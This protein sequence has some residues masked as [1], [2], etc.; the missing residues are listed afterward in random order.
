MTILLIGSQ[1]LQ[2]TELV[3]IVPTAMLKA[4]DRQPG[5][6]SPEQTRTNSVD[7]LGSAFVAGLTGFFAKLADSWLAVTGSGRL[8]L[9]P[10]RR[11]GG[12]GSLAAATRWGKGLLLI[13]LIV[14]VFTIVGAQ[15]RVLSVPAQ[16]EKYLSFPG[17]ADHFL[18]PGTIYYDSK[19]G[20]V[21]VT[22]PGHNRIA[23]FDKSG[24]FKFEFSGSEHY[25]TPMSLAVDNQGRI[26]VLGT[27]PAGRKV[28]VFDFDGLYMRTID[29][30]NSDGGP[31]NLSSIA[32]DDN[33]NLFG[34]DEAS[35]RIYIIDDQGQ[36]DHTFPIFQSNEKIQSNEQVFG[37]ISVKG[38][39]LYVPMASLGSVY[40]YDLSGRFVRSIG[41]NGN[42]VG[43]LNFPIAV[44]VTD[45]NLVLV[46]D[47]HRFNVVCF[48]SNGQFIGEF[49]GKGSNPGWFYH[50][51]SIAVNDGH[52]VFIG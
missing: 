29:I 40:V 9:Q 39:F 46:L 3:E 8:V 12:T 6:T 47:K 20:E 13:L 50:P 18:R 43:E 45:D 35:S 11:A 1:E 38:E 24:S 2:F 21:Y 52:S 28:F 17:Q 32:V 22:D 37:A 48:D 34:L 31:V 51:S 15:E 14:N 41:Y 10:V 19:F 44:A 16:F 30:V 23:I 26:F 36:L 7:A 49:G 33:N 42:N 25:S 27:T 4:I 5:R